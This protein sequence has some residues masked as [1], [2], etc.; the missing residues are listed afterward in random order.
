MTSGLEGGATGMRVGSPHHF[1]AK[2]THRGGAAEGKRRQPVTSA[3]SSLAPRALRS[4]GPGVSRR[5]PALV[6]ARR[7]A[8][9]GWLPDEAGLT[10]ETPTPEV[11]AWTCWSVDGT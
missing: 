5:R 2:R 7:V 10:V 9:A 8:S 4:P 11:R 1:G 3:R 6:L